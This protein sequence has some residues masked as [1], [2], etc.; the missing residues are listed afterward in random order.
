MHSNSRSHI[1]FSRFAKVAEEMFS[2]LLTK[3]EL[4]VLWLQKT[5]SRRMITDQWSAT[6]SAA[7]EIAQ[8]FLALDVMF[9]AI[10]WF[11][12]FPQTKNWR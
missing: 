7:E 2:L 5:I 4:K 10:I 1:R 9:D 11:M 3:I 6:T 12:V 8:W